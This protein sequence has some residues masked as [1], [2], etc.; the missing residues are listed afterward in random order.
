MNLMSLFARVALFRKELALLWRA[1]LSPET[2]LHLRALMLIVPLYL[3]SPLDLIPDIIPV[4]GWVDDL[5][6]VP[7]LV[8]WIVSMLPRAEPV[9]ATARDTRAGPVID[10]TWRRL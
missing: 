10:G 1:F 9:R 8:G 6:I 3:L 2:P 4:L 5:L 7:M